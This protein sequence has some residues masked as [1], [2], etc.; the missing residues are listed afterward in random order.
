MFCHNSEW[1]GVINR[2]GGSIKNG[3]LRGRVISSNSEELAD[4]DL[5]RIETISPTW[6]IQPQ[7]KLDKT[8]TNF[9]SS[10]VLF[11]VVKM[12]AQREAY[13]LIPINL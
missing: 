12:L 2:Y 13:Y 5:D 3:I 1:R 6:H 8:K 10:S 4:D 7:S 9:G 11:F